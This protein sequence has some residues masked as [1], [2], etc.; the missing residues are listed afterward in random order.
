VTEDGREQ[1]QNI[2]R[3]DVA[4]PVQE[5]PRPDGPIEGDAAAHRGPDQHLVEAAGGRDEVDDPPLDQPI[6][7]DVVDRA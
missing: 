3:D 2:V 5:R 7:V 6:E 4:A 1:R